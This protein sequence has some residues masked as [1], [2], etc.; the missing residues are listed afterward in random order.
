MT[1][2]RPPFDLTPEQLRALGD[3][4]LDLVLRFIEERPTAPAAD[5]DGAF[6]LAETFAAAP[7]EEPGSVSEVLKP[8]SSEGAAKA[9]DTAGPGY[10]AYIPGGGLFTS[11]IADLIADVTNRFVNMAA[12]APSFAAIEASV[13]RWLCGEFDLPEGALGILTSGGSLANFSAV[14]TARHDKLPENFLDGTIYASEHVHH[15]IQKAARLAGFPERAIRLVPTD[16]DL[17]MEPQALAEMVRADR[18]GNL[19]PFMVVT[20]AGTTNTGT[21]DPLDDVAD[22]AGNEGLWLHVDAAYGGFFQLTERGRER[23]RGIERADSITLDPHKGM[24]LPYGLGC[25]L[26]RDA[27][28]LRAAHQ[29]GAHYLQDLGAEGDVPNFADLS[30]ELSRDFRGLRIWLP[31]QLHGVAA[32]RAALD[33]KLDLAELSFEGL[34]SSPG[35]EVPWRPELSIVAFLPAEGGPERCQPPPRAH[36][37]EPADLHLVDG[38]RRPRLSPFLHPGSADVEGAHG[39]SDRDRAEGGVRPLT[40]AQDLLVE[41]ACLGTGG[42]AQLIRESCCG[43][44]RRGAGL[45][46]DCRRPRAPA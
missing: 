6:E 29:V 38:H 39:R 20:S 35:L 37:R 33:E 27:A 15:S 22:V 32:W 41:G 46:P 21:I 4:A 24:F 34:R 25:L 10:L 30:P 36:Q 5:L 23:F 3:E 11:A 19:T 2:S 7:P 9:Y 18:D 42:R 40:S 14:V 44:P 8:G 26:V 13:L 43:V 17:K 28:K 45:R 12:P 16:A 1:E 31:L